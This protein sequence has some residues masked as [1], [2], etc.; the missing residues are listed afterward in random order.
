MNRMTF[1]WFD[2][3][4]KREFIKQAKSTAQMMWNNKIIAGMPEFVTL[5]EDDDSSVHV[6]F[7]E[8]DEAFWLGYWHGHNNKN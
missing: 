1:R 2:L 3:R 8:R 6:T 5:T 7:P 4:E